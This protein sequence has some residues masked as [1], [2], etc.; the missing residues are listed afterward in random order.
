MN[1]IFASHR[2]PPRAWYQ[3]HHPLGYALVPLSWLF[4]AAASVRRFAYRHRFATVRHPGIPVIVAGNITTGG[5]GKTPLVIWL[6]KFLR[7]NDFRPA[8]VVRGYG[9]GAR[10]WP[11]WVDADADPALVGDEAVLLAHRTHAPVVAAPD[12]AAAARE[13]AARTDCNVIL[14]DD[15][16]Q[17]YALGRDVEIAVLDG[18]LGVGNGRCLPAGP[19][20]EP[21]SRLATVDLVVV[22]HGFGH[23]PGRKGESLRSQVT[24]TLLD[25]RRQPVDKPFNKQIHKQVHEPIEHH[26]RGLRC[27]AHPGTGRNEYAMTLVPGDPRQVADGRTSRPV[28]A[29][30][31]T[32]V[33][34]V[35][36]IGHPERFFR[37][38]RQLDLDIKPHVFA[39]HHAFR[40]EEVMF[41]D[42]LPVLMTEKDAVKCRRFAGSHH[43]Y[44]PVD[45]EPGP[46]FGARLLALL[47]GVC[48]T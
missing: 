36:G 20:R 46:L 2:Y 24:R 38:L 4:R 39:D 18:V 33:H 32:P 17:H 30:R 26:R 31:N 19:L 27:A 29:F 14:S 8:I 3:E 47:Q 25:N 43:W 16:L 28:A 21:V 34:A 35:C 45:A 10:H 9:G 13:L 15:G 6:A 5:T 7:E 40:P 11:Q 1:G 48:R 42:G 23:G 37:T 44:L 22:N 12:R 41:G